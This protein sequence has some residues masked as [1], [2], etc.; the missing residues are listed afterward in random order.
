[1]KTLSIGFWVALFTAVSF[2][3][4]GQLLPCGNPSLN[5]QEPAHQAFASAARA[6]A[7]KTNAPVRVIPVV[8]HI[9]S[10][11]TTDS[12]N[13]AQSQIESSI[14][15]L[16]KAF[17]GVNGGVDAEIEFCLA[18]VNRIQDLIRIVNQSDKSIRTPN[19]QYQITSS[20]AILK[21]HI[22]YVNQSAKQHQ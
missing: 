4:I 18:G 1:M 7:R 10:E 15:V 20:Q 22:L 3:A 12:A 6:Y 21:E 17:R 11:T 14:D 5:V 19:R 8:F 13:I 16:N 9:V 2:S